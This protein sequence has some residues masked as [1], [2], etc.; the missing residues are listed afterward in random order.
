MPDKK[1]RNRNKVDLVGGQFKRSST[2]FGRDM[3]FKRPRLT[4]F[5]EPEEFQDNSYSM[6]NI[7]KKSC[8]LRVINRMKHSSLFIFHKHGKIR[9][10]CLILTETPENIENLEIIKE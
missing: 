4:Q 9:K 10:Y 6:K 1:N 8:W 5:D 7:K 2:Q 3:E